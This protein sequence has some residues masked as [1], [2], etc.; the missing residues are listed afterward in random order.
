[1]TLLRRPSFLF[2]YCQDQPLFDVEQFLQ[3]VVVPTPLRRL[4]ALPA[5]RGERVSI[6]DEQLRLIVSLPSS[7][8]VEPASEDAAALHELALEGVVLS[9]GED[10]RLAEFRRR[11]EQLAEGGWNAFS[12]LFHFHT[13]WRDND[14]RRT[15]DGD[16]RTEDLPPVDREAVERFVADRGRPPPAFHSIDGA[17]ATQPLPLVTRD[18]GLFGVLA[19]RRTTRSF[20]R[21]RSVTLQELSL[22]LRY[23]FGA[24]GYA[25]LLDDIVMLKRTSPSGGAL[26]PVEAYPLVSDVEGVAPGLYHYRAD[27]HALELL[28]PLAGAE[29]ARALAADFM[30]GQTYFGAAHV[31][32]VMTA[33]FGRSHWKYRHHP[34]A[35]PAM[36]MDAAHLSQTLYL[37]AAE[38]GLGAFVTAAINSVD[39]DERLELDGYR[40]GAL[41]MCGFGPATAEPSPFDPTFSAYTPRL[42]EI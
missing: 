7:E 42:T 22:V 35:Y 4:Y 21:N 29:E 36:L 18:D 3:G 10:S 38:L 30:C 19:R 32:L 9:D 41:A 16:G 1:M 15:R 13:R 25:S 31:T 39:V 20:D 24:H 34:K 28:E 14:L 17:Q 2:F 11:D 27:E 33:R 40:E 6:S 8:W 12:A 37:V 23:V 5:A 26:H